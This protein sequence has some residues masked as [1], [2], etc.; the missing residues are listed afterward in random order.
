M[1][2]GHGAVIAACSLVR[3]DVPAMSIV[4]GSPARV[5]RWLKDVKRSVTNG[6]DAA[7][8]TSTLEEALELGNRLPLMDLNLDWDEDEGVG[9][10]I[11]CGKG[12]GALSAGRDWRRDVREA[13]DDIC[14]GGFG[15][16][17]MS[18]RPLGAADSATAR[19]RQLEGPV[20]GE[21]EERPLLG[22]HSLQQ[23]LGRRRKCDVEMAA[24]IGVVVALLMAFFL[25]GLYVGARGR[26]RL[27]SGL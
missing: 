6:P 8:T 10:D 5:V 17:S 20:S 19:A 24:I 14:G 26:S 1:T 18:T 7:P 4:A 2:V 9:I 12:I 21:E 22:Q 16:C 23:P 25:G 11:G 27:G 13:E 15:V 3:S